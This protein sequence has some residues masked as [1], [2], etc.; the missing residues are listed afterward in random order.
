V[1]RR[2]KDMYISDFGQRRQE[3]GDVFQARLASRSSL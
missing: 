1:D 2:E 3:K